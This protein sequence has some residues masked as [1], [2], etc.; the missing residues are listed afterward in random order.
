M[1]KYSIKSVRFVNGYN[2][3]PAHGDNITRVLNTS[4]ARHPTMIAS[5]SVNPSEEF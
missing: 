2:N 3:M 1:R 4:V 5:V